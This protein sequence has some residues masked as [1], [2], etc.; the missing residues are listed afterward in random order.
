VEEEDTIYIIK[1]KF[2]Y[3]DNESRYL[4]SNTVKNI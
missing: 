3:Y 2:P 1:I 4:Q